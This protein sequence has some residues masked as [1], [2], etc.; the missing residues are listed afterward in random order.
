M[1]PFSLFKKKRVEPTAEEE[2][3]AEQ[4]AESKPDVATGN[5]MLDM[6]LAKIKAQLDSAAEM[7]KATSERFSQISEQI[8]GLRAMIVD[9]DKNFSQLEV[10][11]LKAVDMVET[12]QPDKLMMEMQKMEGKLDA[13]KANIDSNE[14]IMKAITDELKDIRLKMGLFKGVEQVTKMLDET[15]SDLLN[16][17]KVDT[18]IERHADKVETIFSDF[19]KSYSEYRQITDDVK[20]LMKSLQDLTG[21]V[22]TLKV[23]VSQ[24][25]VKKEYDGLVAKFSDF[26]KHMGNVMDL[27]EK[28]SSEMPDELKSRFER[29]EQEYRKLLDKQYEKTGKLLK[30]VETIERKYPEDAD[31]FRTIEMKEVFTPS[32]QAEA[33]KVQEA[34]PVQ[35]QPIT[36]TQNAQ[37]QPARPQQTPQTQP[38][39]NKKQGFSFNF[40]KKKEEAKV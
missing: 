21:S 4:K 29:L 34:S 9:I 2:Q 36:E 35:P 3:S 6:E 15:K 13:L 8:G 16:V 12:V 25:A 19:Q 39:E 24:T 18:N 26:E 28:K 14:A 10:K 40:F 27:L 33:P 17:K 1:F 38:Q 30:L 11:A 22:D 37:P 7:R 32:A 23:K 31:R 5:P 20:I